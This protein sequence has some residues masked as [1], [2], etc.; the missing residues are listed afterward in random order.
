MYS[1]YSML[2]ADVVKSSKIRYHIKISSPQSFRD[3]GVVIDQD[4]KFNEHTSLATNKANCVA[5]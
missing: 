3:L 2:D 5:T 4:L 1:F